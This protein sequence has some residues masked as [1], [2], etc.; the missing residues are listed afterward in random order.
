MSYLNIVN[1][2]NTNIILELNQNDIIQEINNRD[3]LNEFS[4]KKN[5]TT[6]I[7][8]TQN[9]YAFLGYTVLDL[10]NQG[11]KKKDFRNA[12]YGISQLI[13]GNFNS[14]N[15]IQAGYSIQDVIDAGYKNLL[16]KLGY[17]VLDL[18]TYGFQKYEFDTAGFSVYDLLDQLTPEQV[19]NIGYSQQVVNAY[20]TF[21]YQIPTTIWDASNNIPHKYPIN[22]ILHSFQ[23]ISYSVIDSSNG[24]TTVS[25]TWKNDI[26]EN[27]YSDTVFLNDADSDDG[28][29]DHPNNGF[30]D[31]STNDGFS[32]NPYTIPYFNHPNFIIKQFGGIP[33]CRNSAINSNFFQGYQFGGKIQALDSPRFLP[34]T[35]FYNAFIKSTGSSSN[36]NTTSYI[37]PGDFQNISSW[38][39]YNITDLRNTFKDA[40][41]FHERIGQWNFSQIRGKYL[42]NIISGAGYNPIQCSIFLQ[43][44]SNNTSLWS[45][46]SLGTI[47]NYYINSKTRA[48]IQNLSQKNIT[49]QSTGIV[50]N[51]SDFRTNYSSIGYSSFTALLTDAR[52]A[53]F[54]VRDISSLLIPITTLTNFK[55]AGYT[56]TEINDVKRYTISDYITNNFTLS[57]F[58]S[59][60]YTA[61]DLSKNSTILGFGPIDYH[62]ISYIRQ[63]LKQIFTIDQLL[64]GGYT[65]KEIIILGYS[66]N[67]IINNPII[68]QMNY[69]ILDFTAANSSLL[70]ISNASIFNE[71]L[72]LSNLSN[73]DSSGAF[74]LKQNNITANSLRNIGYTI[75]QILA[76]NYSLT[77]LYDASYS[78]SQIQQYKVYSDLSYAY[79]GYSLTDISNSGFTLSHLL[80]YA[81]VPPY[82]PTILKQ[83]NIRAADF[84]KIGYDCSYNAT[85]YLYGIN[86]LLNAGFTLYNIKITNKFQIIDF[87]NAG[88]SAQQLKSIGYNALQ[89]S[90][91]IQSP[92]Y[93][94]SQLITAGFT[95]KN[96]KDASYSIIDLS[97]AN[98]SY[99]IL[100]Y[101]LG[102]YSLQNLVNVGYSFDALYTNLQN[103]YYLQYKKN[104]TQDLIP[105]YSSTTLIDLGFTLSDLY[106]TYNVPLN[107]LQ[108]VGYSSIELATLNSYIKY[109]NNINQNTDISF[110]TIQNLHDANFN[111]TQ[112]IGKNIVTRADIYN[113]LANMNKYYTNS[114]NISGTIDNFFNTVIISN[115]AILPYDDFLLVNT[116]PPFQYNFNTYKPFGTTSLLGNGIDPNFDKLS[117]Y[118][119]LNYTS[120]AFLYT[121]VNLP[122]TV[123]LLDKIFYYTDVSSGL[124][125]TYNQ[126]QVYDNGWLTLGIYNYDNTDVA[127]PSY[128]P[129]LALRFFPFPILASTIV[130]AFWKTA[131]S[132]HTIVELIF[133][134]QDMNGINFQITIN[135]YDY[136]LI[137]LCNG[138]GE[139]NIYN[140][141]TLRYSNPDPL[142][143][144]MGSKIKYYHPPMKYTYDLSSNIVISQMYDIL[145]I[146]LR[147]GIQDPSSGIYLQKGVQQLGYLAGELQGVYSQ[148]ELKSAGFSALNLRNIG[149]TANQL[150]NLNYLPVDI[151]TAYNINFDI[152][153]I[154]NYR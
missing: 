142:L 152:S 126:I 99:K 28:Y 25:I 98:P 4:N 19:I 107:I 55:F 83:N 71:N 147:Y 97:N 49:F 89:I 118:Q 116:T 32:L 122:G 78:I 22:N 138:D 131:S 104:I 20:R 108:T 5:T 34:N 151:V 93:N 21:I 109:Y 29:Y 9:Y 145:S 111:A 85:V 35:C 127:I 40:K 52:I 96:L 87:S 59:C 27:E 121:G 42:A 36:S 2:K 120:F 81:T 86:D 113:V 130:Y 10:L 77:D 64:T 150:Y 58:I 69:S 7:G 8:T 15:F 153:G 114:Y 11:F 43:D 148:S 68:S 12:N 50:P 92:I 129:T 123:Y 76:L 141:N 149:Y 79:A 44:L 105:L 57:D 135:I 146:D 91:N 95:I 88:I 16:K 154:L 74:F 119:P 110:V 51:I 54:Q 37:L 23:D 48:A 94:L 143:V 1:S 45:D 67:T 112:L 41:Y 125:T 66:L 47:P 100:D 72:S 13:S 115:S 84:A 82:F 106:I 65:L 75:P 30:F 46:I 38:Q 53:G 102:G 80:S 17:S 26:L 33:F 101:Y 3:N 14:V 18:Y 63:D 62:N 60:G 24:I 136:G 90:S 70:D 117:Y 103:I 140:P 31:S 61:L 6:F 73:Y 133:N 39:T 139:T 144:K 124:K 134:G 137:T 128:K 56:I 132:N